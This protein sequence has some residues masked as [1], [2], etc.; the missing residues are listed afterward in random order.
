MKAGKIK[1]VVIL[2]LL[3]FFGLLILFGSRNIYEGVTNSAPPSPLTSNLYTPPVSSG[4][5]VGTGLGNVTSISAHGQTTNFTRGPYFISVY[6]YIPDQYIVNSNGK[7]SFNNASIPIIYLNHNLDTSKYNVYFCNSSVFKSDQPN[8]SDSV[9]IYIQS[10]SKSATVASITPSAVWTEFAVNPSKTNN[11]IDGTTITDWAKAKTQAWS[12]TK[13]KPVFSEEKNYKTPLIASS[14][15]LN[16]NAKVTNGSTT[17]VPTASLSDLLPLKYSTPLS[18]GNKT[19]Y[20]DARYGAITNC[21]VTNP[22]IDNYKLGALN[23]ITYYL[24]FPSN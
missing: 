6:Y 11:G 13:V 17:S 14:N 4:W 9:R 21:I 24:T 19:I 15:N 3:I 16:S 18:S 5:I 23:L 1:T 7:P 10:S 8:A 22:I 20:W 12:G 2:L